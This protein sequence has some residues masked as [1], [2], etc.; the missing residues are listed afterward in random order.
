MNDEII[1]GQFNEKEL[2]LTKITTGEYV[3]E[4]I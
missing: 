3:I 4:S 2:Q 1:K